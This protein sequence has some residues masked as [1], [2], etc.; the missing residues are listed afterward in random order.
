M[1]SRRIESY[2]RIFPW[3]GP[4]ALLALTP[5]CLLVRARLRRPRRRARLGRPGAMRRVGG[6]TGL[7]G[8][9]ARVGR[10]RWRTQCVRIYRELS[11]RSLRTDSE[12]EPPLQQIKRRDKMRKSLITRETSSSNS[13]D[14][15]SP[16]LRNRPPHSLIPPTLRPEKNKVRPQ[17]RSR[18]PSGKEKSTAII[19]PTA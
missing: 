19:N 3:M 17:G 12:I 9:N 18:L 4:A 16:D 8:G 6:I 11:A 5:K 15:R 13:V 1:P 10:C 2:R 14:P 7:M